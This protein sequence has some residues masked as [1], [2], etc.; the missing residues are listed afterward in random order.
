[1]SVRGKGKCYQWLLDR[2]ALEDG[3]CL[4][5]PFFTNPNG[6]GQLGYLGVQRWAHRIMC[7]LANGLAPTPKHEASHSCGRGNQGCVHPKHLEWKTKVQNR[8]DC[9]AHGTNTR[10]LGGNRGRLN[11]YQVAEIRSLKGVERQV[12]IAARFGISH[13]SVGM[14]QRG[15]MYADDR[16]LKS[17]TREED[18]KIIEAIK[19]GY[20]FPRMAK[21]IGRSLGATTGRAYRLG[22][23]SGQPPARRYGLPD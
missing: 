21:Y 19:L 11:P 15:K 4:I 9:V 6:Y 22:L 5:W 23:T 7:E 16:T 10:N 20:N 3:D 14:I 1:M 17:W 8:A 2:A 13:Q 18:A 12:D